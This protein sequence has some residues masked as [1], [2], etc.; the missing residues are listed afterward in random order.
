MGYKTVRRWLPRLGGGY[1]LAALLATAAP[2]FEVLPFFCWFLFPIVPG[3]DARYELVALE[4]AGSPI[5]PPRDY[6]TLDLVKDPMAMDL[7]LAT[8]RL[9][10]ALEGQDEDRI[11]RE[12]HL[13]ESNF[14]CAPSHYAVDRVVFDPLKRWRNHRVEARKRLAVFTSSTG[15]QILPWAAR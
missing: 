1:L 13:I 10:Q 8:R 9:G 14:L 15:C 11:R 3:H 4:L 12:R 5:S 2:G 6:Q 7:W